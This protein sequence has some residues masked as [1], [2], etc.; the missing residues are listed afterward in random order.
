MFKKAI[1]YLHGDVLLSVESAYPERIMNLC[2]AH[3]IPFWDV[4]LA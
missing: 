1:N 4:H 2:S 3:A